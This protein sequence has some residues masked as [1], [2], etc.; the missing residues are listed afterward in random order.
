MQLSAF[1][2]NL[3]SLYNFS[4]ENRTS[5]EANQLR[6][7]NRLRECNTA[8]FSVV[9]FC[10]SVILFTRGS[11]HVPLRTC[12]NLFTWESECLTFDVKAFLFCDCNGVIAL[13]PS[14]VNYQIVGTHNS[15]YFSMA[16]LPSS[17]FL[18][19]FSSSTG[20]GGGGAET[21][22]IQATKSRRADV[23]IMRKKFTLNVITTQSLGRYRC[24]PMGNRYVSKSWFFVGSNNRPCPLCT[25][26]IFRKLQSIDNVDISETF[27]KFVFQSRRVCETLQFV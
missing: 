27:I 1:N 20:A 6:S 16:H 5:P 25:L 19:I 9:F 21:T 10:W 24:I 26:E 8:V 22:T 2:E 14:E 15:S 23:I 11:E 12:S 17:A 7:L 18:P 13:H 3:T 4:M